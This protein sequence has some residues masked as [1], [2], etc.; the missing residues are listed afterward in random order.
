MAYAYELESGLCFLTTKHFATSFTVAT[1]V[2]VI[3]L[4]TMITLYGII[5]WHITRFNRINPNSR[6]ALRAKRNMKVY[7]KI[8]I[9]VSILLVGGTP[10]F[11]CSIL[12][13]IGQAPWPLYAIV[14][15]FIAFSA[16]LESMALLFTNEQLRTILFDLLC[17]RQI[18]PSDT[19]SV[20]ATNRVI[21]N[22]SQPNTEQTIE[23]SLAIN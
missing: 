10:F 14:H 9:F 1:L 8:F 2:F 20:M 6:S 22:V 21:L 18:N 16:A 4:G 19:I 5:I 3:T 23:Q 7:R 17:C 15:L 13:Q 11:L 12:H